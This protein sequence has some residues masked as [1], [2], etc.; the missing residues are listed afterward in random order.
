M[1]RR[2]PILATFLLA[3]LHT[4]PAVAQ[5]RRAWVLTDN[6]LMPIDTANP[7]ATVLPSALVGLLPGD[8][9]VGIDVRPQN[10]LV[11]GL[12]Y[13]SGAGTVQLYLLGTR[14]TVPAVASVAAI[15]I[16]STGTFVAA[17][18]TTPVPIQGTHFGFDFNPRTDRIRVV[19]DAGQD[20]RMDPNTGAFVDGDQGGAGGSFPGV[21][22]DG[23]IN[24]AATSVSAAAYTNNEQQA[25]ATTLYTLGAAAHALYIQNP[26]NAGTESLP[27]TVMLGGSTLAF[28]AAA[29]FD[30][31]PGVDVA[32]SNA[33]AS[34]AALAAL[35]VGGVSSLYSIDLG[36]AIATLIGPIG[37]GT[38]A[39]QGL[40]IQGEDMPG[41]YPS[42]AL[43][44][45]ALLQ[46]NTA[47]PA[48]ATTVPVTGLIAGEMLA[49][50]D[51]R[52]R[53][54]QLMALGVN[55][56][57]GTGSATLYRLD[58]QTGVATVIGTAGSI[59]NGAG[60]PIDLAHASSFGFDADP[61][62]DRIRV[63][64]NNGLTFR[65]DPSTG[66]IGDGTLDP[67]ITGLPA[68]S[69]GV[70]GAAYTNSYPPGA[71]VPVTT[72]Y[73]LDP[74]SNQLFIQGPFNQGIESHPLPLTVGGG[75]LD[76]DADG[77]FDIAPA[78]SAPLSSQPAAGHGYAVL[79]T[80]AGTG[81]YRIDLGTGA[82]VGLGQVGGSPQTLFGLALGDAPNNP[83]T[84][85]LMTSAN[86]VNAGQMLTFTAIVAPSGAAGVTGT[87]TF[88]LGGLAIG[89][90]DVS[91]TVGGVATCAVV[92]KIGGTFGVTASYGGDEHHA[93]SQASVQQTVSPGST[94]TTLTLIAEPNPAPAGDPVILIAHVSALDA[95]G[96]VTFFVDGNGIDFLPRTVSNGTAST[97]AFGLSAGPHTITATYGGDVTFA[98][99]SAVPV[100][101]TVS[102]PV[103]TFTQ[104]FAEGATGAF[105]HT[106][107]GIFNAG[108]PAHVRV[109]A[110]PENGGAIPLPDF[111]LGNGGRRTIDLNAAIGNQTGVSLL[112]ESDQ[113]V[114]ATRQMTWGNPVYGSTLENGASHPS[115]TWHFAEGATNVFSLFYLVENPNATAASVTLTHLLEGGAAPVVQTDVIPAFTRR[116]YYIND[117]P[118][119]RYAALST[120]ITADI[121]VV[122][123]RAMYLNT[124]GRLWEGGTAGLGATALSNVWGFAEGATGF[125]HTYLLLGN[126][127]PGATTVTVSYTLGNGGIQK[128]Y[129]VPGQSRLTIDVNNE[130]PQLAST[131]VAMN[132][133]S[134]LPIIAER[135]MWWG[136]PWT[137][138]SASLGSTRAGRAWAIGEGAEGGPANES[139]FVLLSYGGPFETSIRVTVW[140]DDG[141]S[142][143]KDYNMFGGTRLT[144]R[145]AD[146]FPHARDRRFSVSANDG[147]DDFFTMEVARYQ[148]PSG[149]F[150]DGG[151]AALATRIR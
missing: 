27:Q 62:T 31:P 49:G 29:G 68:G 133:A 84:V 90:R 4:M 96:L 58:P 33:P 70:T 106:D 13:N 143:F 76:F 15:A 30:I 43:A 51:W 16:G 50:I 95:T 115:L 34:G 67:P 116:T 99:S 22:M 74:T 125:F 94:A 86:P 139:T 98:S 123:E 87:V 41:G 40:A 146:E 108:N 117:V 113:P 128:M 127:N 25:T 78:V 39:I 110:Y 60:S 19:N 6:A 85:T 23:A 149:T 144:L 8:V 82:T 80:P 59:A 45:N 138:G 114:A 26:P 28:T 147:F 73:A 52:P 109:T 137:D 14:N 79:H 121:P 42:I 112:V 134:T 71:G 88:N 89:C 111:T 91:I 2:F 55:V 100:T 148:S 12:G 36:T 72:L 135:A 107:L 83:T 61:T 35:T 105:F 37:D 101:I 54:G 32:I 92:P 10:G 21:N 48:V 44:T 63:V 136:D 11:Y 18:G 103:T 132:L 142:D 17:D 5:G 75:V 47:S 1:V 97:Q 104:Y 81:L 69:T 38:R 145:V 118:G 122:A 93:T 131:T 20:F 120:V 64:T 129:T 56:A 57:N 7:G 126:P 66:A 65:I 124:S 46:F 150:G 119:L 151:G 9:L 140:Y 53:T 77:G 130:D 3:F 141:T 102:A 24:G